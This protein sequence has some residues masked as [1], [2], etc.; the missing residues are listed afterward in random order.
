[1]SFKEFTCYIAVCDSCGEEAEYDETG[2][3]SSKR[4]AV[5]CASDWIEVDGKIICADCRL[6]P[7]CGTKGGSSW[8]EKFLCDSCWKQLCGCGHER[9]RHSAEF[10]GNPA[11]C[12]VALSQSESEISFCQCG[13]FELVANG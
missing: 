13:G 6:C 5:V 2:G 3:Y 4:D 8:D 11:H 10:R 12:N 1:M 9:R 7:E